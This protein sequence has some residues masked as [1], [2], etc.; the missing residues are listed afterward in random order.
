MLGN[1]LPTLFVLFTQLVSIILAKN[2]N[3]NSTSYISIRTKDKI[4]YRLSSTLDL[5]NHATLDQ[6]VI[7]F[8]FEKFKIIDSLINNNNQDETNVQFL[9][10]FFENHI[11]NILNNESNL[12][13][14]SFD[15]QLALFD[16]KDIAQSGSS[17]LYDYPVE[18]YSIFWFKFQKKNYEISKIND[19]IESAYIF[20]EEYL[21]INIDI[22]INTK[23]I[24]SLEELD[25][26]ITKNKENNYYEDSDSDNNMNDKTKQKEENQDNTQNDDGLSKIWTEGLIMCL[27]VSFLLLG[28]L[29]VALSWIM[30]I[31][32]S[33]TAL[34]KPTNPIKKTQ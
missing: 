7:V 27:I 24:V 22:L 10:Q 28:I 5:L 26:A 19:F 1:I 9:D 8:E 11:T 29:I 12:E 33:Y 34:E 4:N 25:T 30:S 14:P 15:A 23:D 18:D 20:L 2:A 32:I 21:N 31:E 17:I 3:T 16:I 6:P 13:R